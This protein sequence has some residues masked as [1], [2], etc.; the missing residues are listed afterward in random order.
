MSLEKIVAL[1]AHTTQHHK[2]QA[3]LLGVR[4]IR[5]FLTS[6]SPR[7]LKACLALA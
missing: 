4:C 5:V 2:I 7:A 6:A 3:V 1:P